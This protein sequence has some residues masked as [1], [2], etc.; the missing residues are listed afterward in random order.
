L[1][2]DGALHLSLSKTADTWTSAEIVLTRTLGYGTYAFVVRDLAAL[3]P[4]ALLTF[5]TYDEAGPADNY[6][7][8]DIEIQRPGP[9]ARVDGQYI[10]Q[11]AYM[12]A[13]V[14]RFAVP[15]GP[16]TYTLRWEPGRVVFVAA[17]GRR[18]QLHVPG[19]AEHEVTAGVPTPGQEH[20]G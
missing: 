17:P 1:A 11:P 12:A 20:I 5:F 13:H 18:P 9:R 2:D 8:M 6:R 16:S 14:R 15:P 19:S 7:E 4:A 3:D 10:L